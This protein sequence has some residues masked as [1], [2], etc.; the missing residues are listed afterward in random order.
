MGHFELGHFELGHWAL[1]ILNW[2]IGHWALGIGHW[3]LRK[4]QSVKTCCNFS[5]PPLL[6]YPHAQ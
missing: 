3:A 4:R 6:P 1:G 2:G 5:Y